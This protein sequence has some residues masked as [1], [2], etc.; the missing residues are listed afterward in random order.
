MQYTCRYTTYTDSKVIP[1]FITVKRTAHV[2]KVTV[3]LITWA[4]PS[5]TKEFITCR[6]DI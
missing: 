2:I 1:M 3:T 5:S 6:I 4:V